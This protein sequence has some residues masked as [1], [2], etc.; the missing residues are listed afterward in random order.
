MRHLSKIT[1]VVAGVS[2]TT[3]VQARPLFETVVIVNYLAGRCYYGFVGEIVR[4][5]VR[6]LVVD[7]SAQIQITHQPM[8]II[9]MD[10]EQFR[11]L[12]I[13]PF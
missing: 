13:A 10:A 7:L 11:C 1:P 8:Q 5:Q 12:G 9:G 2:S 4:K 3:C 6:F